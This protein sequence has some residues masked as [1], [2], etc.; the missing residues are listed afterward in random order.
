VGLQCSE[1]F[2]R[3][4]GVRWGETSHATSARYCQANWVKK[5][6]LQFH[7]FLRVVG[8]NR[9]RESHELEHAVVGLLHVLVNSGNR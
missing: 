4:H 3:V 2:L 6:G 5:P 9:I 1:S 8:A 7:R